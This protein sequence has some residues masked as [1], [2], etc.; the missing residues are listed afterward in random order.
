MSPDVGVRETYRVEGE[1]VITHDDYVSGR[2]WDDSLAYAFYPVDLHEN[3]S[4]VH[5]KH[6][7]EGTV[8]TVPLRALLANGVPNL[9]VAGRCVSSDRLANSALRV[10]ATC[11][12]CGQAAGA[13]AALAAL[14]DAAPGELNVEDIKNALREQGAIVP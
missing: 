1:Y 7:Q 9:L 8:A 5:P 3:K 4:G 14:Q 6:L 10:Q 13:A 12:A 11:M 2:V